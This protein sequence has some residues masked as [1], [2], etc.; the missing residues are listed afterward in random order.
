MTDHE[1]I[2]KF[3]IDTDSV[4]LQRPGVLRVGNGSTPVL[5]VD[6]A[7][8][9]LM[10]AV[11]TSGAGDTL[12]TRYEPVSDF[13]PRTIHGITADGTKITLLHAQTRRYFGG[14]LPDEQSEE[15]QAIRVLIG[16]HVRNRDHPFS[17][18]RVALQSA[19]AM[20]SP[21]WPNRTPLEDGGTVHLEEDAG[22]VWLVLQD[23]AP[24][25]LS[26]LDRRYLRPLCTLL[27]LG[28]GD[29]VGLLAVQVRED[30]ASPWW[31]IHSKAHEPY[32]LPIRHGTLLRKGDI[33]ATVVATWLGKAETLGPLPPVVARGTRGSTVLETQVLELTTVA[34]GLHRRL[35]PDALRFSDD[36]GR[37]V[38][39]AAAA[40]AEE[41]RVGSGEAVKGF[42]AYVQEIGYGQRLLD[43]A[44][45]TRPVIP[46]VT[47][48]TSRWKTAV[49]N[50]RNDFAHRARPDWFDD[51]DYDQYVTVALS[52][53]WLLRTILL[54]EAGIPAS[55]LHARF[56]EHEEYQLFLEQAKVWQPRIY[57][58]NN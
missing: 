36:I 39:D 25:S 57:G 26:V 53:Q 30:S 27:S 50:A 35:R 45:M 54:I 56:Q 51:S 7:L 17:G 3:W 52:V 4:G 15:L 1:F 34:E 55:L 48:R 22:T 28:I 16:E 6:G 5:L 10:Q 9:S 33:S 40:A 44:E 21:L 46:E 58:T 29:A 23:F 49:Y 37:A 43:L 32:D 19:H 24:Q 2:G 20:L 42:L 47:G 11:G 41:I 18:I 8:T 13:T 14:L 38:R 12:V 31:P